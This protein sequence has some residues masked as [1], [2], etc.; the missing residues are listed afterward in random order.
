MRLL[1]TLYKD[2][3]K[4]LNMYHAVTLLAKLPRIA[5][6]QF[7]ILC[8]TIIMP[9]FLWAGSVTNVRIWPAPDH[10]RMVFDLSAPINHKVFI[11]KAKS[12]KPARLVIDLENA[13]LSADYQDLMLKDTPLSS[14]RSASR[15][16]SDLRI[17]LEL[18]ES[19][20]PKSFILRPN[21]TYGHRLVVDLYPN[22]TKKKTSVAKTS[23]SING[24][25]DIIVAIDAGHGGEDPGALGPKGTHEKT[26]VLEIAKKLT[27]YINAKRGYKA[28]LVRTG[29]YY[30][31]LRQ[32]TEIAK[33]M[34]ADLFVSIHADAFDSPKVHGAS[35]F[36][37]S[38]KGATSETARLLANKENAADLIGGVGDVSLMDKDVVLAGVLLDLS[39]TASL[40]SSLKVG[41][42]VLKHMG[43]ATTLH[44][45]QIEQAGFAV[46]KSADIPSILVET[47]FISNPNEEN[48]LRSKSHQT[49]L[50]NS[51]FKGVHSFFDAHPPP[52]T[53]LAYEK[54]MHIYASD[55]YIVASGDTLSQIA[56]RHKTTV[57]K[58][59]SHNQ[60]QQNQIYIGQ[61]IVIPR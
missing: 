21:D 39:M 34:R 2:F 8:L 26:V 7:I 18:K 1:T 37:L 59:K 60:L 41:S 30:V 11:L 19:V 9:S 17:V 35:V 56:M 38:H 22:D 49:K 43:G 47:G 40:D 44:K 6:V 14:I 15:N 25:R 61:A 48:K 16:K 28:V 50:A 32:R 27:D 33:K 3:L 55:T 4:K 13:N 12:G 5:T 57:S 29:D 23:Q 31:G 52:D 36:A 58:L 46:L 54:R 51:I 53:L 20:N 45:K 42:M 10:T 24:R